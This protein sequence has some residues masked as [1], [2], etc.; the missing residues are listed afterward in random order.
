MS[1]ERP[2]LDHKIRTFVKDRQENRCAICGQEG[3]LSVHHKIPYFETHDNSPTNLVALCRGK[4]TNNCHDKVDH[5]TLD[6][7]IPFEKIME[8][9]LEYLI[10][11]NPLKEKS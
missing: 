9:G 5:L 3:H 6:C 2:R 10:Q 1:H 4:E 7:G 11:V 8:E